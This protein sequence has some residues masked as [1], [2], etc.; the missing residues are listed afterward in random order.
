LDKWNKWENKTTSM[1]ELLL[2][3]KGAVAGGNIGTPLAK[4]DKDAIFG[5]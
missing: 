3:Q 5:Y 4:L 2:K 1:T